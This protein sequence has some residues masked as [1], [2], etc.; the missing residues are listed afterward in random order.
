MDFNADSLGLAGSVTSIFCDLIHE[1]LGLSYDVSQLSNVGD[2]LAP[3]VVER[4]LRSFMDYYYL[5]KYSDDA[6]EWRRVMDAL[7]VPETYFWREVDQV[8]ALV[9]CVM[10]DLALR[11]DGRPIRI[12]SVPCSSGEEPL[13]LAMLLDDR[14]WFSRAD[15]EIV[16]SDASPAA[17]AKARTGVYGGRAF[18]TLPEAMRDRYFQPAGASRWAVS[19]D[20]QRRVAYDVVNLMDLA[21]V[22]AHAA[23][24]VIFCRNVFIYFSDRNIFRV[25][26]TFAEVMSNPGVLCVGASESLLRFSTPFDLRE[27]GGAFVYVKGD[28]T[29]ASHSLATLANDERIR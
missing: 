8:L 3:L 26:K 6:D 13:T 25:V 15:I 10:P 21:S 29:P 20:L 11:F 5:L 9:D 12:W 1:R 2:R 22:A 24:P 17:I 27:I 28:A 14:G 23:V 19:P 4:G 16:A 18:R 7:A